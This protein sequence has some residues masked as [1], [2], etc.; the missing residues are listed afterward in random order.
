MRRSTQFA[1]SV[2]L[3]SI[4]VSLTQSKIISVGREPP[5]IPT[6]A[7]SASIPQHQYHQPQTTQPRQHYTV[8]ENRQNQQLPGHHQQ[9]QQHLRRV[10]VTGTEQY[11]SGTAGAAGV[12]GGT[13]VDSTDN[14][15]RVLI[16][17]SAF[18]A[19]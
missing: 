5:Q 10:I 18:Y 9:N 14:T 16:Q 13:A 7:W 4:F 11:I 1:V 6:S 19:N 15:E 3:R 17:V 2:V 8:S 12:Q